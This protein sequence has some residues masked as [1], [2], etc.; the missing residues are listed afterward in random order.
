VVCNVLKDKDECSSLDRPVTY[1]GASG[2][3]LG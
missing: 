2:G 3:A 1:A